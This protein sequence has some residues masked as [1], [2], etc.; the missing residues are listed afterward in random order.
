[1]AK[2]ASNSNDDGND[3]DPTD[4]TAVQRSMV[5][6]DFDITDY[7]AKEPK[8]APRPPTAVRI[9][10]RNPTRTTT[11]VAAATTAATASYWQLDDDEAADAV[12]QQVQR[13]RANEIKPGG[14]IGITRS[15]GRSQRLSRRKR[16]RP[17]IR[18]PRRENSCRN[19]RHRKNLLFH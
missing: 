14:D 7:A 9:I 15:G 18:D 11:S 5:S 10:P 8:P 3:V 6:S 13:Q 12:Y 17:S 19:R 4:Y 1:M 16:R 2:Y